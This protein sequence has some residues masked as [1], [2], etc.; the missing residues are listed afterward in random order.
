MMAAPN[1]DAIDIR[2]VWSRSTIMQRS[3]INAIIAQADAFFSAQGFALP[4]W[5]R[6]DIPT[7]CSHAQAC[8]EIFD[9]GL[10]WDITD[11]GSGNFD[12]RGLVLFTLR[13]GRAGSLGKTYAEKVMMVR[14]NQ[15]TP[16]HFHWHKMEDIINRGG[17]KLV[18]E[19]Y[20]AD[21][22]E[23]FRNDAFSVQ[24]DGVTTAVQPGIPLILE[25]G[26]SICLVSGL[27]HRFHAAS[28]GGP[29]LCGEVSMVNDDHT[30]NRFKEPVG[31]FP[32]IEEDA[33]PER[34][35]VG[36]YRRFL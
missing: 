4:G 29:V 5:S 1:S 30:D 9:C 8:H 17:G 36:D 10:G 7:W 35:M 16:F 6:W 14:E 2:M 15:E 26:Q 12:Q 19:L 31:R 22:K 23:G 18:F 32:D 3:K 24:L 28:G 25:P 34:L 11:F 13:N 33:A 20:Q 27:Y 21:D